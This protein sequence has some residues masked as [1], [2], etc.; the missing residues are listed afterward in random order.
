MK[1]IIALF[2][3]CLLAISYVVPAGAAV[4]A[5]EYIAPWYDTIQEKLAAG[6][7]EEGV[8]IVGIDMSKAKKAGDPGRLAVCFILLCL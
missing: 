2:L 4:P 1:R 5:Q 8:V 7:Y 6:E 3:L